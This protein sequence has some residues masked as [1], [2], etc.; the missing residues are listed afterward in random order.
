[1]MPAAA[2]TSPLGRFLFEHFRLGDARERT[3]A[4]AE[5]VLAHDPFPG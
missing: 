3:R 5:A 4:W 1:M 2:A